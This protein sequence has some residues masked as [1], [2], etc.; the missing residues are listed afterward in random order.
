VAGLCSR[1]IL[2]RHGSI[3]QDGPVSDVIRTYQQAILNA[4]PVE[5]NK[6]AVI[7]SATARGVNGPKFDFQ[8]GEKCW[9]DVEF[10]AIRDFRNVVCEIGILDASG[11][12]VS[13]VNSQSLGELPYSM[14]SGDRCRCTFELTLHLSAGKFLL[15]VA[16][17]DLVAGGGTSPFEW[18][19]PAAELLVRADTA[20]QGHVNL[21][22]KL[23]SSST[24]S[25]QV[26]GAEFEHEPAKT[27]S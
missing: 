18:I 11:T 3:V 14:K 5:G 10:R 16:L 17:S 25:A 6:A 26:L 24:T 23:L 21:Y 15:G 27:G 12:Y 13:V 22:P 19:L 2:L 20:V 8:A 1:A 7:E 9:V 4:K